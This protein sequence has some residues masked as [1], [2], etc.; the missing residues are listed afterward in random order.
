MVNGVSNRVDGASKLLR[1]RALFQSP[2]T[3]WNVNAGGSRQL[4]LCLFFSD[5]LATDGFVLFFFA[6]IVKVFFLK[7]GELTT[8]KVMAVLGLLLFVGGTIIGNF[9]EYHA[10]HIRIGSLWISLVA[11]RGTLLMELGLL[12]EVFWEFFHASWKVLFLHCKEHVSIVCEVRM[13]MGGENVYAKCKCPCK[14]RM[15]MQDENVYAMWECW[16]KVKMHLWGDF[17]YGGDTPS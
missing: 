4:W 10:S 6:G 8:G 5:Y 11:H 14:I 2:W 13:S 7:W 16:W 15:S 9:S 12:C 3:P 17:S 1:Q